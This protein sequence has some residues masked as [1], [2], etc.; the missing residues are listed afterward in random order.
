[1]ERR[2]GDSIE[3]T[4]TFAMY[5]HIDWLEHYDRP[6]IQYTFFQRETAAFYVVTIA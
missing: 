1:M 4:L 3:H 2:G 5:N 6:S